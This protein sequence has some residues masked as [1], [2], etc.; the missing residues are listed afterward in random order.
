MHEVLVDEKSLSID[1]ELDR[2]KLTSAIKDVLS[3]LSPREETVL[4]LRFGITED[5]RNYTERND[6]NA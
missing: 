4:R 3:D 5:L 6:D 1:D 2:Q